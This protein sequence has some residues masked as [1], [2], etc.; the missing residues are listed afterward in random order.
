MIV[1]ALAAIVALALVVRARK[2][3]SREHAATPPVVVVLD[4][5]AGPSLAPRR[6][7]RQGNL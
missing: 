4:R 1:T 2:R 6:R 5:H 7:G 3:R